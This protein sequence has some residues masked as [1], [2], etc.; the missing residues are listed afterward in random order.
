M[1]VGCGY[2]PIGLSLAA[3]FEDRMVHMIDVNERAVEL[4]KE[5]ALNNQIDNIK[6]Y[7]SDLFANVEP[8]KNSLLLLLIPHTRREKTVHAIFEKALNICGLQESCGSSFRK[9]RRAFCH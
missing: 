5:N 3:D 1:D 8:A 4:S 2:G 7:Q 9:T 6:I